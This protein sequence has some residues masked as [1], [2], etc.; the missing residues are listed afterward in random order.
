[1]WNVLYSRT[2]HR[3]KYGACALHAGQLRPLTYTQN[4]SSLLLFHSYNGSTNAHVLRNTYI[5]CMVFVVCGVGSCICDELIT[6]AEESYRLN[7]LLTCII[8][9]QYSETKLI[10]FSFNF[11]RIKGLY[12]FRASLAHLQE[13]LHK[14]HL[15]YCVH[16]KSVGCY[17]TPVP[18]Q[19]W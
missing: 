7:V 6:C 15:V 16:V 13:V 17:L 11:L 1:M 14:Q 9:Y 5:A 12:M 4:M 19:S 3:C 18:S 2:G 10:H 8:V